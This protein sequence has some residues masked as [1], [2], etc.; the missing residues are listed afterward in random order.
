MADSI[1]ALGPLAFRVT[2]ERPTPADVA[3]LRHGPMRIVLEETDGMFRWDF[4]WLK[5]GQMEIFL[6]PNRASSGARIETEGIELPEISLSLVFDYRD[7]RDQPIGSR[8]L[9]MP[10]DL[11]LQLLARWN[12]GSGAPVR[13]A[14]SVAGR[15]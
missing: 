11:A 9:A 2:V 15:S 13:G 8:M 3:A 1:Q 6:K 10:R 14:F 5:F 12:E 4:D 7:Q